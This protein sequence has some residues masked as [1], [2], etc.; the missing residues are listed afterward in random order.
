[1]HIIEEAFR[2]LFPEKEFSYT[3]S[4]KYS[5]K[6]SDYNA[7]V[8]LRGEVLEFRMSKKLK[9]VSREIKIG[10][11]QELLLKMFKDKKRSE[12]N[13]MYVDLYNRFVKNLGKVVAPTEID[14][15]L[16]QSFERVNAKYFF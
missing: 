6:F 16:E 10:L 13:M 12:R 8:I 5:G 3:P 11:M 9:E 7:H 15:L 4:L 14:P 2:T 1:M